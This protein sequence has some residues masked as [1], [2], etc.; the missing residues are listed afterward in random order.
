MLTIGFWVAN[1]KYLLHN[2]RYEK[3]LER[4][5]SRGEAENKSVAVGGLLL[6]GSLFLLAV[7]GLTTVG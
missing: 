1:R 6:Y 7:V 2:N 5:S 4:Y 3:I